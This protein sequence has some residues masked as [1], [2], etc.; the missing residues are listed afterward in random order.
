MEERRLKHCLAASN[1]VSGP[2]TLF[3]RPKQCSSRK[4]NVR[5]PQTMFE[6]VK[7]WKNGKDNVWRQFGMFSERSVLGAAPPGHQCPGY[8]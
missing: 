5:G 6:A 8:A 2:Q 4:N 1:N 3:Q 7:Q